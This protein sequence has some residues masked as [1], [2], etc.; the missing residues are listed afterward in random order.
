MCLFARSCCSARGCLCEPKAKGCVEFEP[1]SGL[2]LCG[3]EERSGAWP[4]I[5]FSV[6][7]S[8]PRR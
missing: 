5:A 2:T 7:A 4:G 8:I 3:S 1:E 6:I